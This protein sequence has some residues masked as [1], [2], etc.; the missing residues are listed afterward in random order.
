MEIHNIVTILAAK[1]KQKKPLDQIDDAIVAALVE[2]QSLT[3][4]TK[5]TDEKQLLRSALVKDII[6]DVRCELNRIHGQFWSNDASLSGHT[7]SAE[8]LAHYPTLYKKIFAITG[9]PKS[10]LD[11]GCGLNPL[12][13]SFLGCTPHY[14]AVEYTSFACSVLRNFFSSE[15]IDAEVLQKDLRHSKSFPACDVCFCFKLFDTLESK[16]HKLAEK[17]LDAVDCP[18]I[19][20]SFAT[21]AVKGNPMRHARRGWLV[22]LCARKEY[23][24]AAELTYAN[25][26]FYVIKK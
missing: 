22:Q 10:I 9:K 8:R 16:H 18:W 3:N 17:L 2:R 23:T 1:V 21:V 19:V 7:S 24:I 6:K 20:V 26:V 4:L 11:L 5:Y 14:V 25:E 13:Y 12:S 15:Q